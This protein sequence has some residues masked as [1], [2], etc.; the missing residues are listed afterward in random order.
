MLQK[1]P[2]RKFSSGGPFSLH[3]II[4][5]GGRRFPA[6]IMF[7]LRFMG[8]PNSASPK[9]RFTGNPNSASLRLGSAQLRC[10]LFLSA[11]Q[12]HQLVQILVTLLGVLLCVVKQ[13]LGAIRIESCQ[14]VVTNLAVQESFVVSGGSLAV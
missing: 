9:G 11:V 3:I 5:I 10:A 12:L 1:A 7:L 4:N 8:N 13:L 14:R 2:K 6:P